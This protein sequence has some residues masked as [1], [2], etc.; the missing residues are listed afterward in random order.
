MTT[1]TATT[2]RTFF[3]DAAPN[4]AFPEARSLAGMANAAMPSL[5]DGA[6]PIATFPQG[7][8]YSLRQGADGI[9]TVYEHT[10]TGGGA[11]TADEAAVLKGM[12]ARNRAFYN[13]PPSRPG[14]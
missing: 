2:G 14:R 4:A 1:N 13:Q 11:K 10:P 7:P 12:N 3:Q 9:W 5:P 6:Y 8:H